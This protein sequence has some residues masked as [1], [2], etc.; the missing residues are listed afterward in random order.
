LK[1]RVGKACASA[2]QAATLNI[3]VNCILKFEVWV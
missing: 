1:L 3:F 2:R